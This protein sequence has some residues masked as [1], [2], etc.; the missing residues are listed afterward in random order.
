MIYLTICHK[1][2]LLITVERTRI[3]EIY[4]EIAL[5]FHFYDQG[6]SL[7]FPRRKRGAAEKYGEWEGRG[8]GVE[9]V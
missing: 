5:N 8:R 9:G 4:E 1:G 2:S 3:K 7:K 6:K